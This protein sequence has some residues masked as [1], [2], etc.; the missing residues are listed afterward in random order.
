[1][2]CLALMSRGGW[3]FCS[4]EIV[5]PE[6][7]CKIRIAITIG[8]QFLYKITCFLICLHEESYLLPCERQVHLILNSVQK[9]E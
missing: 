2:T 3:V 4:N 9:T 7:R 1:M 6:D 5:F 8:V